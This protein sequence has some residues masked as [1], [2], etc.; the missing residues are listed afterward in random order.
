[1][2]SGS[3]ICLCS[4]R[5]YKDFAGTRALPAVCRPMLHVSSAACMNGM[6][7]L[8]VESIFRPVWMRSMLLTNEYPTKEIVLLLMLAL[9]AVPKLSCHGRLS[10]GVLTAAQICGPVPFPSPM[11][12]TGMPHISVLPQTSKS[13]Y[14]VRLWWWTFCSMVNMH[15]RPV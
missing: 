10:M 14:K 3:S 12:D 6:M 15:T 9:N 11:L 4:T 7:S 8:H 5:S 1:L 2:V 13:L